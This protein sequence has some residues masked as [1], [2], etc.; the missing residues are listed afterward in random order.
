MG[1]RGSVFQ[2][3]EH[4]RLF[5]GI[6]RRNLMSKAFGLKSHKVWPFIA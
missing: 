6:F 2:L 3:Q 4:I 1:K 5:S